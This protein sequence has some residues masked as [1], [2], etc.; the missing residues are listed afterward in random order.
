MQA[1]LE[2]LAAADPVSWDP[3]VLRRRPPQI[4]PP[5]ILGRCSHCEAVMCEGDWLCGHLAAVL[6]HQVARLTDR[7]AQ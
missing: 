3:T 6:G 5:H 2:P 7:P 4:T 1:V